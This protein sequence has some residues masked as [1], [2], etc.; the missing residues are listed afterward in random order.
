[1][2]QRVKQIVK[3]WGGYRE[4]D[5]MSKPHTL[6]RGTWNSE[7]KVIYITETAAQPDGHKNGF[8]VDIVTGSICG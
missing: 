1:M 2:E 8:A 3:K 5:I 6:T 7:H 4:P